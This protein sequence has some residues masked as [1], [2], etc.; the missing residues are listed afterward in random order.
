MHG[1]RIREGMAIEAFIHEIQLYCPLHLSLSLHAA[2]IFPYEIC[3]YLLFLTQSSEPLCITAKVI[4]DHCLNCLLHKIV[5]MHLHHRLFQASKLF[6]KNSRFY[7]LIH[8]F[9]LVQVIECKTTQVVKLIQ[10][11]RVPNQES[12]VCE[13][14]TFEEYI[15]QLCDFQNQQSFLGQNLMWHLVHSEVSPQINSFTICI[16]VVGLPLLGLSTFSNFFTLLMS[17]TASS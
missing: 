11:Q 13:A 17:I 5:S 4:I 7:F 6:Q 15:A 14:T 1:A 9:I 2:P 8:D 16:C 10:F 12:R 3:F